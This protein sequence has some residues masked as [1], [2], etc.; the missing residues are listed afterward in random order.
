MVGTLLTCGKNR[1]D[2]I[3]SLRGEVWTHKTSL[4][5]PLYIEVPVPTEEC[6]WSCICMLGLSNFASIY[7]LSIGYWN[8]SDNIVFFV[9]HFFFL[10]LQRRHYYVIKLVYS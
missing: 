2:R 8:C 5:P 3:I 10:L 9:F 6:E 7:D 4:T 1:H